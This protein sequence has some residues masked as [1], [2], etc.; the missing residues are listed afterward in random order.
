VWT[1]ARLYD[2]SHSTEPDIVI[3]QVWVHGDHMGALHKNVLLEALHVQNILVEEQL[4]HRPAI[5]G[6]SE[7][8]LESETTSNM[9]DLC[10]ANAAKFRPWG[11]HSP[12]MFWNCSETAIKNDSNLLHTIYSQRNRRSY[13]NLTL[14]P[15]SVFAGKSFVKDKVIAADALVLTLF[16]RQTESDSQ[17]W[18]KRIDLLTA[19]SIKRGNSQYPRDGHVHQSRLYEF[20][21]KPLSFLDNITLLLGYFLMALYVVV[22]L[23]KLRA[24]KSWAGLLVTVL[25]EIGLSITA[26]FSVCGLLKIDLARIPD[27]AYPF[28]VFVMG[29]ENMFRLVNAVLAQKPELSVAQ[30]IATA[31]SEVGHLALATAFQMLFIL[32]ILAKFASGIAPFCVFAAIALIFDFVF[33]LT[34]FLAVLSVDVRRMELSDS[35]DKAKNAPPSRKQS[36]SRQERNYWLDAMLQNRLPF[37]SRIAGSAIS[38][39]FCL[40]LNMHFYEARNGLWSLLYSVRSMFIS[41]ANDN[42]QFIAP[43]INQ[44]RTPATWLRIQDYRHAQE[45]LQSVKPT[46]HSIVARVYDPLVIVLKSSNRSGQSLKDE[47]FFALLWSLFAKHLYPFLLAVIFS[48]AF[49]TLL[50]QYLLWNELPEEESDG[51]ELKRSVLKV[52]N[53]PKSHRLDVIH[54]AG[55]SKG[56]LVSVSLDRLLT[57]SLFDQR[58]HLY[59]LSSAIATA[60]T[61]SVW[62]IVA[63]ALDEIGHWAAVCSQGGTVVFW[64]MTERRG[65]HTIQIDLNNERPVLFS[66]APMDNGS[67]AHVFLFVGIPQGRIQVIDPF[68]KEDS[69]VSFDISREKIAT[70]TFARSRFGPNIIALTKNGRLR[71]AA[72]EEDEWRVTAAEKFDSRLSPSSQEGVAKSVAV[73]PSLNIMA[74]VRLRVIDL[75]DVRTKTQIHSFPAILVRGHSLR[76][77]HS[78]VRQCKT[79]NAVAVHSLS[80]AYADFESQ[81]AVLRTYALSDDHNDLICLGPRL[82]GKSYPCRGLSNAKEHMA[83]VEHP[84]SWEAT[85]T[86]SLV[87]VRLKST[88]ADTPHS[89]LS[90]TSGFDAPKFNVQA[91]EMLKKRG[92]SDA[93][94]KSTGF[95]GLDRTSQTVEAESDDWEVWTLSANGEFHAESLHSPSV[96]E[97][98]RS[99]GEDELLVAAPGP[100]VRLGQ[101]SVAVGFGNR[102]KVIMLG[103]ERFEQD[104]GDFQDLAYQAGARRRKPTS[105]RST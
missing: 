39:C 86:S 35:L 90:T 80:L 72:Q 12:L 22:S 71:I 1:S 2:G 9:V 53:L 42:I 27:A 23:T 67:E 18:E 36:V 93:Q 75:I 61:P 28:V 89:T 26:S 30:R 51:E 69:V 46:A 6:Q 68:T 52:E 34:F 55:S 77:L 96:H 45:V 20:Q 11:F 76:V 43:P 91:L 5:A 83:V 59:S 24:V 32:W 97:Q 38:V 10:S 103:N 64:N 95:L 102:V 105:K 15:T 82:A 19:E 94:P 57:F 3:R 104:V 98:A 41:H 87:G 58:S 79:C 92:L 7:H 60:M 100:V 14:R 4:G 54:I 25:L 81:S 13:R 50:M 63:L 47:S 37:S 44:A 56:H 17:I 74:A 85:G 33:H 88:G 99:I 31:L 101:R 49:V 48:V 21:Q 29:L 65:S 66:L 62:P 73:A 40:G 78:P 84:G 70:A 8:S 16:G